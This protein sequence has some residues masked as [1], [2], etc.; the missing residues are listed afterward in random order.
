MVEF[1][2]KNPSLKN[3][4]YTI[5]QVTHTRYF[6]IQCKQGNTA[7]KENFQCSS[8]IFQSMS[9]FLYNRFSKER[10]VIGIVW[11]RQI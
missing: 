4:G 5:K 3:K 7:G 9:R 10:N 2:I 8:F 6:E 11:T 1:C